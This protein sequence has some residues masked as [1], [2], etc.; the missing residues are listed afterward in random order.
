MFHA[1]GSNTYDMSPNTNGYHHHHQQQT[2]PVYVPS[3]RAISQYSTHH[4]H[5]HPHFGSTTAPN[6]QQNAWGTPDASAYAVPTAAAAL[7]AAA[8]GAAGSP[9][10]TS[11][12]YAQNA[13]MMSQWRAYDPSGFQRNSPYGKLFSSKPW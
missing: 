2:T 4:Q 9:T 7:S 5:N 6:S 1:N 12:F 13:M 3:S 10:L 11:Q 8:A